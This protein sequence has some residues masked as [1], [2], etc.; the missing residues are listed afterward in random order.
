[1]SVRPGHLRRSDWIIATGA[2][3]LLVV[4][5]LPWWGVS[6]TGSTPVGASSIH[7]SAGG[8]VSGWEWLTVQRWLWLLT[9]V[10][11]LAAVVLEALTSEIE[12]PV[13]PRLVVAA[14]GAVSTGFIIYR[15]VDHPGA[16]GTT[17][18]AQNY[19][20]G[21]EYGIWLGLLSAATIM[22]GGYFGMQE[23]EAAFEEAKGEQADGGP[24]AAVAGAAPAVVAGGQAPSTAAAPT[25]QASPYPAI[26]SF[27]AASA[28][29]AAQEAAARAA[30]PAAP[31][32]RQA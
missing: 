6:F 22:L 30:V 16:G 32:A 29:V 27:K 12:L 14:L 13:S 1:M 31:A 24:S 26:E 9:I 7:I 8:T 15:I 25:A 23:E 18:T 19:T 21:I 3:A 2:I 20:Y 11:A 4:M 28:A 10:V 5:F 17:G